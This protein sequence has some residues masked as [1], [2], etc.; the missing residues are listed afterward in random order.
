MDEHDERERFPA[1]AADGDALGGM[2]GATG[3]LTPD[4]PDDEFV[5]AETREIGDPRTARDLTDA[6]Y[7]RAEERRAQGSDA[8]GRLV[9][10][11]EHIA[12]NDRDGGYGS[13]HGLS[14]ADPAHAYDFQ[15]RAGPASEGMPGEGDLA[16]PDLEVP[17]EPR[18]PR[19]PRMGVDEAHS[20]DE[21]HM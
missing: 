12:P 13:E 19:P 16:R 18:A 14:A 15:E 7:G 21:E 4:D 9:E 17:A 5:P 1:P 6:A 3:S 11:G 8:P 2:T 20:P 10:A